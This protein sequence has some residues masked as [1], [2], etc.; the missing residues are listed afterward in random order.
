MNTFHL[1]PSWSKKHKTDGK[2]AAAAGFRDRQDGPPGS[3]ILRWWRAS[4]QTAWQ[5]TFGRAMFRHP[6]SAG[7]SA[8]SLARRL[9]REVMDP[10]R[11]VDQ[12]FVVLVA[13]CMNRLDDQDR[14][15]L[16]TRRVLD[17]LSYRDIGRALGVS[18][19]SV[20]HRLARARRNLH[21]LI[22]Q[23]RPESGARSEIDELLD[24]PSGFH[25]ATG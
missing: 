23:A 18:T 19:W 22:E 10:H 4:L 2:F 15:I 16:V 12:R 7:G 17:T 5:Q 21:A 11:T 1:P 24:P 25:P 13:E 20:K 6:D 8:S 9:A 14:E 3:G